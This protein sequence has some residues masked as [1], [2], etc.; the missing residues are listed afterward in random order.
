MRGRLCYAWLRLLFTVGLISSGCVCV[1][2]GGI[3]EGRS[4]CR[5]RNSAC[6]HR[7]HFQRSRAGLTLYETPTTQPAEPDL[8]W[9]VLVE[10]K[11]LRGSRVSWSQVQALQQV[12]GPH[13]SSATSW[14]TA[15]A[16][17]VSA[18]PLRSGDGST[19][20]TRAL[21]F[22]ELTPAKSLKPCLAHGKPLLNHYCYLAF[23]VL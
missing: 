6:G 15:D 16:F 7:G 1:W 5:N 18:C 3:G 22:S 23:E 9:G 2:G 13:P 8:V 4:H 17:S 12:V 14:A 19:H 20:H 11:L 10:G 21:G